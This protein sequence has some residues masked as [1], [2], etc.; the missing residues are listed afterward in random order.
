M[1][2]I[3]RYRTIMRPYR[4]IRIYRPLPAQRVFNVYYKGRLYRVKARTYSEAVMSVIQMHCNPRKFIIPKIINLY[5]QD[6]ITKI[7]QSLI[8]EPI[9]KITIYFNKP[10]KIK[11]LG[12]RKTSLTEE[13]IAKSI[14]QNKLY[15]T[16][17]YATCLPKG[18][19]IVYYPVK[20]ILRKCTL[21]VFKK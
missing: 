20:I 11:Y 6:R 16:I 18:Y 5:Q 10:V 14:V 17:K 8:K 21:E 12:T 19:Y 2:P 13:Q 1:L 4:P 3:R 7:V 15:P 9:S